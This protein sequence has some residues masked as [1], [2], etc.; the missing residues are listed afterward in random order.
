[1][2]DAAMLSCRNREVRCPREAALR[3]APRSAV[4]A[5]VAAVAARFYCLAAAL[6]VGAAALALQV[7][8]AAAAGPEISDFKLANGLEV[9]V[10][11]DHRTPVVTHMIWYKVGSA[12]ETPGKSGLAH[13]LE[14]LMF[15]GTAKNPAGR[16]SQ[17]LATIGGQENA[18]TTADYTA[19]FQRIAKEYLPLVMAFEADRMTG[20]VLTDENVLPERD[21]VLEEFNMRVAN[22]PEARIGEQVAAALYLNHPY[23]RPVIGWHQEIEKLSREDA[24]AFYRRFYTPNN[25]VVVVAGDVTGDEV[26]ALAETT[27]GK[28]A[29][30]AEVP[31]RTRPEEPIPVAVR[32]LTMADARVAQPNL[33]RSYL[34]PS[35]TTAKPGES[36]ALEILAQVLGGG[37]TS[38]LY[39]ALV[40]ERHIATSAGGW[41]QGTALDDTRFGVFASP[42]PGV[43]F[44]T[45]EA[46]IDAVIA[47]IAESGVTA[48][49]FE[50][51]KTRLIADTV[52]AADNQATM[53]GWYGAALTS[54][55]SVDKVASWPARL[56]A[57][58]PE[59]VQDAA[60]TWL[61]KRRSA[62]GYL[63][64]ELPGNQEKRS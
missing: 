24:L 43:T 37:E 28:V 38:R 26:K 46:A 3:R 17:T 22:S 41:Y 1:M 31:P 63:V 20:L 29:R 2:I 23:G 4:V 59:A 36:E 47:G 42:L 52:Y 33:Q 39:R 6:V 5:A 56:R 32:R 16:F 49:E 62:T 27:Y 18:F 44:E 25:A 10:I 50:R 57:V 14:H 51:A 48:G 45:V 64:K 11:P 35:S 55:G 12:D 9:V 58:T 54:G 60:R 34:V 21:V 19:Y 53:A 15:K 7:A 40:I 13:F 61:D 30:V 8:D